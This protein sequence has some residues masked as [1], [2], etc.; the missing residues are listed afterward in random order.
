MLRS[1]HPEADEV[2]LSEQ[3]K[4]ILGLGKLNET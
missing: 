3:Y 4:I 1:G 2:G